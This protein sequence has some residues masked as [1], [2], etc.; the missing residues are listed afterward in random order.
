[1]TQGR[2]RQQTPLVEWTARKSNLIAQQHT[3]LAAVTSPTI[4]APST[5]DHARDLLI[6]IAWTAELQ[7]SKV[8]I[9]VLQI[10][11]HVI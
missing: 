10:Q 4:V 2:N 8:L 6:V 1:M 9:R 5:L 3:N 11:I 7:H